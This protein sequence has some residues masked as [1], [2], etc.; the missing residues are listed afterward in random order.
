MGDFV[1]RGQEYYLALLASHC[2]TLRILLNAFYGSSRAIFNWSYLLFLKKF[3]INAA[4]SSS[5]TPFVMVVLG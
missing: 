3:F 5:N 4:H 1:T 2:C